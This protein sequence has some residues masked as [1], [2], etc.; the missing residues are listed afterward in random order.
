MLSI[1][2]LHK[3]FS[4]LH[5]LKGIDLD[6]PSGQVLAILGPSGSG[7]STLL[8]CINFLEQP[9]KGTIRLGEVF[10][11]GTNYKRSQL[12]SLRQKTSMV[13]QSYQLFANKTCLENIMIP[14]TIVRKIPKDKAQARA[15]RLM[16]KVGVLDKANEYPSRLSGGQ[17]QRV[18]IARALAANPEC[19]LF[20]EPTSSLDP[21]LVGEVLEVIRQLTMEHNC[22]MLI[23]THEMDFAREVADRILFLD[24]GRIIA[25]DLTEKF[26]NAEVNSPRIRKFLKQVNNEQALAR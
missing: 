1:R 13:F 16:E 17:Q 7:K 6:V 3:S 2:N 24:D 9:E 15:E 5:V 10:I 21:E 20:D 26:F 25:D 22:T 18:G 11:D 23:V 4:S 14:M 8:R 19:I 12:R